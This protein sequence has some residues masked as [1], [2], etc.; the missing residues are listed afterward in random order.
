[1]ITTPSHCF[2]EINPSIKHFAFLLTARSTCDS[3]AWEVTMLPHDI[4]INR[5]P[6]PSQHYGLKSA[7][8]YSLPVDGLGFGYRLIQQFHRLGQ[9]LYG[10]AGGSR[11]RPAFRIL[12]SVHRKGTARQ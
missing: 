10:Y 7:N 1:M 6:K 3:R 12:E 9:L 2:N 11:Y 5:L 4:E 8:T